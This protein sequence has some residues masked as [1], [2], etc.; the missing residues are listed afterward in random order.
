MSYSVCSICLSGQWFS[1]NPFSSQAFGSVFLRT[2]LCIYVMVVTWTLRSAG[3]PHSVA[4]ASVCYLISATLWSTS[5]D[6]LPYIPPVQRRIEQT[7][8]WSLKA[9]GYP[10]RPLSRQQHRNTRLTEGWEKQSRQK[11]IIING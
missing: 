8:L 6:N 7:F 4:T 5:W 10:D 1:N 2:I 9:L 3:Y 11:H